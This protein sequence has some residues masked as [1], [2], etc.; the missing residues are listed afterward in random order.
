MLKCVTKMKVK[1][2]N[3]KTRS[4]KIAKGKKDRFRM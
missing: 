2:I 3:L 4:N 1:V